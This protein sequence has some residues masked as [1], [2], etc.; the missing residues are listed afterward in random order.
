MLEM[1]AR[2]IAGGDEPH[3]RALHGLG[4]Q[5]RCHHH[6]SAAEVGGQAI[7]AGEAPF[8]QHLEQQV[9]EARVGLLEFIEQHH[10]KRL[11]A[12]C[13]DEHAFAT[14]EIAKQAK[15]GSGIGVFA[16]VE[17]DHPARIAKHELGQRLGGFGFAH[18][19]GAD[20]QKRCDRFSG[21][22]QTG[23]RRRQQPDDHVQCI[24]LPE[25][26][27]AE[28]AIDLCQVERQLRVEHAAR[29]AGFGTERIDRLVP[30]QG[31][32]TA[33]GMQDQLF[34]EADALARK[35]RIGRE[36]PLQRDDFGHGLGRNLHAVVGRNVRH[37]LDHHTLL[38]RLGQFGHAHGLEQCTETRT[39]QLDAREFRGRGLGQKHQPP[40]SQRLAQ[41]LAQA[42]GIALVLPHLEQFGEVPHVQHGVPPGELTRQHGQRMLPAAVAGEAL[43]ELR[44]TGLPRRGQVAAT[45][46]AHV[47]V[48]QGGLAT[49]F[50]THHQD[51]ACKTAFR[52]TG[53]GRHG[54][55]EPGGGPAPRLHLARSLLQQRLGALIL[56]LAQGLGTVERQVQ[57]HRLEH[58]VIEP[59]RGHL[60]AHIGVA[61]GA[62]VL[63]HHGLSHGRLKAG[64]VG[65]RNHPERRHAAYGPIAIGTGRQK[66]HMG[67]PPRGLGQRIRTCGKL[68]LDV[69]AFE[70]AR[71]HD[72]DGLEIT[73]LVDQVRLHRPRHLACHGGGTAAD[74]GHL[75]KC[76]RG[77]D[78]LS[79]DRAELEE[80]Q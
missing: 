21:A 44:R 63:E 46:I 55:L 78:R 74:P 76:Q 19:R 53:K 77:D 60:L 17:A 5:V 6:E 79:R 28:E 30:A 73:P 65:Q 43:D 20:Q 50:G 49:A 47:L 22:R 52:G 62:P 64:R 67:H 71:G 56:Q 59:G 16:H 57:R 48:N 3:G 4:A 54:F 51:A 1:A 38:G 61:P 15:H 10:R 72:S 32:H 11:S 69:L 41:R 12:H 39:A 42:H 36:T 35:T 34:E 45:A 14:A 33:A 7:A 25:Q 70:I 2:I 26:P 13:P 66:G 40:A 58:D 29:H 80:C 9:E 23:F 8:P 68:H 24:V 37:G 31:G 18:A 75:R 27:L